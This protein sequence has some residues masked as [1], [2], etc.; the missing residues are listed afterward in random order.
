MPP[1]GSFRPF[2]TPNEIVDYLTRARDLAPRIVQSATARKAGKSADA[3]LILADV[4]LRMEQLDVARDLFN[5]A[6]AGYRRQ[7]APDDEQFARMNA[8]FAE[9]F[10]SVREQKP[11]PG[12]RL[13]V[14]AQKSLIDLMRYAEFPRTPANGAQAWLAVAA[15][16]LSDKDT[17]GA[18]R[19][20]RKAYEVAAPGSAA[21]ASAR[22]SLALLGETWAAAAQPE[23]PA[24]QAT[25]RLVPP[26]RSTISGKAEFVATTTP[27][28]ARVAFLLDGETMATA[29]QPPFRARFDVDALPRLRTVKAIAYDNAGKAIGEASVTINDRVDAFRVAIIAPT[30]ETVAGNVILEADAQVPEGKTLAGVDLFWN[31]TKVQSFHARPFRAAFAVPPGFGYLRAV[32]TLADGRTAEDTRVYNGL[33]GETMDVHAVGFSATVVDARGARVGG[34]TAKDFVVKDEGQP[35]AVSDRSFTDEPA[36]IGLA[37][38]SS[39]SMRTQLLDLYDAATQFVDVAASPASRLFVV[40]FD[41]TPRVIH[42]PSSDAKSLRTSILALNPSGSTATVDA[43]TFALQQFRGIGGRRALVVIT[44]GRDG[45]NSQ[46][47]AAAERMANETGV[48]IYVVIPKAY[49]TLRLGNA[50]TGITE[51]SGGLMFPSAAPEELAAIFRRIRDEVMGQYLLSIAGRDGGAGEWRHV[52]VEVPGRNVRVRTISGYYA[53]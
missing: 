5:T 14:K 37:V 52:S 39:R 32:A 44:D 49:L 15:I 38:D 16:R 53:H 43:I 36:T 40:A 9:Y 41:T 31:D 19:A 4:L 11:S 46:S 35:V 18:L 6:A 8:A 23:T 34:L 22:E 28:V 17:G 48:P 12:E 26:P 42:P 3:D 7:H 51:T 13:P 47:V 21:R 20:Y 1:A 30:A 45:P 50:L 27:A 29:Q 10:Y 33:A 25:I 2:T 24:A